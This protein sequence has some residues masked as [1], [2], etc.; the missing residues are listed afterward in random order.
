MKK[1]LARFAVPLAA[2]GGMVAATATPAAAAS[3]ARAY[4]GYTYSSSLG[5]QRCGWSGFESEV[6]DGT[7]KLVLQDNNP[8]GYG[9]IVQY[10]R[11]DMDATGPYSHTVTGG[12]GAASTWTMHM[13]EGT[14][15]SFRVCPYNSSYGIYTNKCGSWVSG[16]A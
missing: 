4:C 10:F 12:Y 9:V 7:E 15:I 16:I 6:G 1:I 14:E 8:D 3:D 5:N 11:Y 2:V 13:T